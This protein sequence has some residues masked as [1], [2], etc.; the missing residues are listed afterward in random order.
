MFTNRR[1]LAFVAIAL[2][3]F[4]QTT[5]FAQ[6]KKEVTHSITKSAVKGF[7]YEASLNEPGNIELVYNVK[8]GKDKVKYEIYEFDKSLAFIGQKEVESRKTRYKERPTISYDYIGAS[9]GGGNSFT[10]LSTKLNLYSGKLT[11]T[12]NAERQRYDTKISNR[13]EFKPKNADNKS[14]YGRVAYEATDGTLYLMVTSSKADKDEKSKEYSLLKVGG[15]LEQT[16]YPISFDRPHSL[17]YSLLVPTGE[18]ADDLGE[19]E[20]GNHEMMFFFAPLSGNLKEYTAIQLDKNGKEKKRFTINTPGSV[21]AINA[22]KVTEDGTIYLCALSL[23]DKKSFDQVIGEYAPIENYSYVQYGVSNYRMEVYQKNIE[24][25]EFKEL[26]T[27][28]IKDGKVLWTNSTPV[29]EFKSKLKTPPA[30]KKGY[31]YDGKN[32]VIENFYILPDESFL[33][34]G[35]V[36]KNVFKQAPLNEN[37]LDLVC[38]QVSNKG[39]VLSQYSYS[40]VTDSKS[41]I[42]PIPQLLLPSSGN[43]HLYWL[44]LEVK[45]VKGYASWSDAYNG[46]PTF[47]PNFYPAIGKIDLK[48]KTISN[49][50]VMGNRK[51]LLN[52]R[53]MYVELPEEKAM[54]FIGEDKKGKIML[55]KF[56]LD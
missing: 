41:I 18:N 50:E 10:I 22:H 43:D 32:F 26:V 56:I 15:N 39:E 51:F 33:F 40:P 36:K 34:V 52:R 49:F 37:Y 55:A 3:S 2:F 8:A 16:E 1:A 23:D 54:V 46:A 19:N 48:N 4:I 30:Q 45:G 20:L 35:Q 29:K 14:Y 28:K 12:W 25:T 21:C 24:K 17:I 9:V 6:Q 5:S 38:L 31:S 42:F 44:A 7:L 11:K 13:N 53:N 47:Y 27:V